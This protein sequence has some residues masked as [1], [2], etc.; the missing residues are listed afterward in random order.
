MKIGRKTKLVVSVV[1]T[2]LVALGI[3]TAFVPLLPTDFLGRDAGFSEAFSSAIDLRVTQMRCFRLRG[4]FAASDGLSACAGGSEWRGPMS[5][6][7]VADVSLSEDREAYWAVTSSPNGRFQCSVLV[8]RDLSELRTFDTEYWPV[9][10]NGP[11][12]CSRSSWPYPLLRRFGIGIMAIPTLPHSIER[13][14]A[15]TEAAYV[16]GIL[17]VEGSLDNLY[18]LQHSW[19][20]DH[21]STLS[22]FRGNVVGYSQGRAHPEFDAI[23]ALTDSILLGDYR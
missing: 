12:V 17:P 10:A 18:V 3:I 22:A 11:S 23:I 8:D 1:A 14:I 13:L 4:E 21:A 9:E 16:G 19:H 2:P 15:V 20:T 7:A 6:G 5:A